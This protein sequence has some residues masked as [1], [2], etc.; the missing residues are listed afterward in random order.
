MTDFGV[1]IGFEGSFDVIEQNGRLESVSGGRVIEQDLAFSLIRAA[2]IQR[3]EVPDADFRAEL[4]LLTRRIASRDPRITAIEAL[5][6]DLAPSAAPRTATVDL[7]V[8]TADGETDALL[9]E[10]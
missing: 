2:S 5:D 4:E 1:G 7:T 6:V 10:I 9:I 3:G 8:A